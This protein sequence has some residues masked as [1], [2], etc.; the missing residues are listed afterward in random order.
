[1]VEGSYEKPP[2][3]E[4]KSVVIGTAVRTCKVNPRAYE[5]HHRWRDSS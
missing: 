1:M 3:S 2:G 5:K 4:G